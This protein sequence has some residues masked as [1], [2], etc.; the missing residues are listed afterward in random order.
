MH[1]CRFVQ[2]FAPVD[3][4]SGAFGVVVA[5][6]AAS[7]HVALFGVEIRLNGT[8]HFVA[9]YGELAVQGVH[10]Q[11][12]GLR[13]RRRDLELPFSKMFLP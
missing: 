9:A 3:G 10:A 6:A 4:P 1:C 12:R 8:G 2:G 13:K 11:L 7:H 5:Q